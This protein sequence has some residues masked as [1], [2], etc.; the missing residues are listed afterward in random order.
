MSL[1]D[2]LEFCDAVIAYAGGQS[3]ES[4]SADVMRRDATL[5]KLALIGEAAMR[6]PDAMRLEAAAI[7]WRK[8]VGTRNRVMH[9]YPGVDLSTIWIIASVEVPAL[10]RELVS[11][12]QRL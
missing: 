9:A 10:R 5:H 8:I 4:W 6:V 11:L 2:M 7:P 1:Q 12:L 3:F